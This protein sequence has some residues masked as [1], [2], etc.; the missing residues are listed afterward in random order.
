MEIDCVFSCFC[1][2]HRCL[3]SRP[4]SGISARAR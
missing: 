2:L 1:N 3:A 4:Q